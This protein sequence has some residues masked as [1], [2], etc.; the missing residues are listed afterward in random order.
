MK[1]NLTIILNY[2][3]LQTIVYSKLKQI[4]QLMNINQKVNL[5]YNSKLKIKKVIKKVFKLLKKNTFF[6]ILFIY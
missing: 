3:N 1:I 4:N 2:Q 6:D 5:I